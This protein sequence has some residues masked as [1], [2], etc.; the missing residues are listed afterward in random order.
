MRLLCF[1][2]KRFRWKSYSKSLPDAPEQQAEEEVK[3]TLVVFVQAEAS[4]EEKER[5]GAVLRQ[6]LKHIKQTIT[7][8][9]PHLAISASGTLAFMGRV[10]PRFGKKSI[11]DGQRT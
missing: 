10:L 5:K 8:G 9:S 7:C 4:D 6:T 3:E 1:Q 2:A 11:S